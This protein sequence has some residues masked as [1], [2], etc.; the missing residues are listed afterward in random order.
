L[1]QIINPNLKYSLQ[2]T[3]YVTCRSIYSIDTPQI[4]AALF[5]NKSAAFIRGRRLFKGGVYSN[6]YS[7][8]AMMNDKQYKRL[9]SQ[10]KQ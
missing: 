9:L 2:E 4:N 10:L 3:E 5:S 8:S 7:R 1:L 6:K